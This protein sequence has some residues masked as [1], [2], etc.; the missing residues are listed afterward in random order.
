MLQLSN[1]TQNVPWKKVGLECNN[2]IASKEHFGPNFRAAAPKQLVLGFF[3]GKNPVF[4][5]FS[6]ISILQ[7]PG[8][9]GQF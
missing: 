5:K 2:D 6:K 1:W 4:H 3:L 9:N 8:A 7:N